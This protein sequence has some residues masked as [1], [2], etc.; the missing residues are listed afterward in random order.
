MHY[1]GNG[2]PERKPEYRLGVIGI[3]IA[4]FACVFAA[5]GQDGQD[6]V[7][8]AITRYDVWH[9][10]ARHFRND[11]RCEDGKWEQTEVPVSE[12]L[13][14]GILEQLHGASGNWHIHYDGWD[15]NRKWTGDLPEIHNPNRSGGYDCS[16]Y[17]APVTPQPRN[18]VNSCDPINGCDPVN[19][20]D[21]DSPASS[22]YSHEWDFN[23]SPHIGFP[24]MPP[25]TGTIIRLW[26]R[27][28]TAAGEAVTI[29]VSVNGVFHLYNGEDN[30]LAQMEVTPHLGIVIT[31]NRNKVRLY[32]SQRSGE[33]ITLTVR[34]GEVES[35]YFIGF[36]EK[37]AN[38]ERL[39]DLLVDGLDR[40]SRRV[41]IDGS[42]QTVYIRAEGD[43]GDALIEAGQAVEVR[44]R[45]EITLDL[46]GSVM[47]APMARRY[48]TLAISWGAM[49]H[50]GSR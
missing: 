44:I 30:E 16:G 4:L 31:H 2:L 45:N 13:E 35:E 37:P 1:R 48:N 27:I 19:S 47:A 28:K 14:N 9:P 7:Y 23:E 20:S 49:K 42:L 46:R 5:W 38:F 40:V 18:P 15:Q 43:E 11:W 3:C 34:T 33:E 6:E 21:P 50:N 22:R 24:V 39:S 12:D 10:H 29:Q 17:V 32:G 41:R 26:N 25:Y 8:P 36:P